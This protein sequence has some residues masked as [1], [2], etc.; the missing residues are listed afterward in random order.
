[1]ADP[2]NIIFVD[3]GIWFLG[4]RIEFIFSIYSTKGIISYVLCGNEEQMIV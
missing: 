3:F 1:M 2:L 4:Y